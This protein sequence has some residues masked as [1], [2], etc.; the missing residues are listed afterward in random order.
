MASARLRSKTARS[1]PSCFPLCFALLIPVL[2]RSRISSRLN[3]ATGAQD[4]GQQPRRGQVPKLS[5]PRIATPKNRAKLSKTFRYRERQF[6]TERPKWCSFLGQH[7]F[8]PPKCSFLHQTVEFGLLA[9]LNASRCLRTRRRRAN[10]HE[11][12][13]R[14]SG[15]HFTVLSLEWRRERRWQ[16]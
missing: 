6:R 3:S 1:R 9:L 13:S 16:L 2:T 5:T 14:S 12:R 10:R 11:R 15:P 7:S 8:K 4:V